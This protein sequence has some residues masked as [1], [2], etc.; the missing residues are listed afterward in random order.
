MISIFFGV[1][2]G[3]VNPAQVAIVADQASPNHRGLAVGLYRSFSDVGIITGPL[4]A[5]FLIDILNITSSFIIISLISLVIGIA[6]L[7]LPLQK[8]SK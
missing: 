4:I 1:A 5:G 7:L 8:K 3:V 6:T 2:S